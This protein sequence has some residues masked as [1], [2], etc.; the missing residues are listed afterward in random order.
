MLA[1]M[2]PIIEPSPQLQ[3]ST[4]I[5]TD[6]PSCC[7]PPAAS[8]TASNGSAHPRSHIPRHS[9]P[10]SGVRGNLSALSS[11]GSF[12][13]GFR[14][15]A[16]GGCCTA[17]DGRHPKPC[18]QP[19]SALG[20]HMSAPASCGHRAGLA[21]GSNGPQEG[22]PCTKDGYPGVLRRRGAWLFCEIQPVGPSRSGASKGDAVPP[23]MTADDAARIKTEA[24]RAYIEQ[25]QG[26]WKS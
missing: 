14:T 23:S 13:G 11:A 6:K 17:V 10:H 18:T 22:D 12:L 16:A 25:L 4:I 21:R 7:C 20:G 15:P 8:S 1:H 24:R 9:I 2:P 5:S 26:A 19:A 3:L